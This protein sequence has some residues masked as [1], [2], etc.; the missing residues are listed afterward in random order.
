VEEKREWIRGL[1]QQH[2]ESLKSLQALEARFCQIGIGQEES[3]VRQ[4]S[5]LSP[6]PTV[7]FML[8]S[9]FITLPP[10]QKNMAS[11]PNN[12]IQIDL[13]AVDDSDTSGSETIATD[14]EDEHLSPEDLAKAAEHVKRLLRRITVLQQDFNG[15]RKTRRR[16]RKVY[17]RFCHKFE[18]GIN[19]SKTNFF[20]PPNDMIDT[21]LPDQR[22]M[23]QSEHLTFDSYDFGTLENFDFDSF[24]HTDPGTK[25][26]DEAFPV[27]I[28]DFDFFANQGLPVKTETEVS[29]NDLDDKKSKGDG[30]ASPIAPEQVYP[31]VPLPTAA[32]TFDSSLAELPHQPTG[33]IY[34]HLHHSKCKAIRLN[35]RNRLLLGLGQRT[36]LVS[37]FSQKVIQALKS[38][39]GEKDL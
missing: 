5:Q 12:N 28:R 36:A 38:F 27:K 25:E 17:Q 1:H 13:S 20:P 14:D 9:K 4:S 8:D 15:N 3:N 2:Q 31:I 30:Y 10:L 34:V 7:D 18:S 37:R 22:P 19:V 32:L 21:L 35:C 16:V 29:R 6:I 11:K 24:L 26:S 39:D 23:P 33:K